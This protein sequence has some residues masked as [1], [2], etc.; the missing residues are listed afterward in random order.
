MVRHISEEV[1]F[2]PLLICNFK[3]LAP[4]H[5]LESEKFNI[6]FS[7]TK[8]I[9]KIADKLRWHRY[10]KALLQREVADYIGVDRGTYASYEEIEAA[11][12][13]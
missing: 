6:S 3:L 7:D 9:T 1:Q 12:T 2:A 11:I 8:E 13:R 4:H 10:K 5:L